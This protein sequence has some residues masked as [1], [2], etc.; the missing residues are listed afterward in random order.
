M[1]LRPYQ[2]DACRAVQNEWAGGRRRT[3]LVL[4][5]GT[6][7]TVVFSQIAAEQVERGRR[8]L[9]LAHR[10]ELLGQA[11]DKLYAV[12]GIESALEKGNSTGYGSML[13]VT[14]GSVQTMC[15][16]AR[17]SKFPHDYFDAI[18]I[19][20]AHHALSVSYQNVLN[21]FPDADVLG[22][23]A[24]PDRGDHRN[25][26][27]YF[28]SKAFEYSIVDAIK[29]GYLCP[30]RAQMIP[31]SLDLTQVRQSAGDYDAAGLGAALGPYLEQIADCFVRYAKGRKTVVF[32]PLIATSQR[33][34]DL[35]NAR[36]FRAAQVDGESRDRAEVLRDFE[37]GRYDVLCNSMLLTEGWDCPPVDCV[38]VL[39]PT[40]VRGLYQQMV[41]RGTRPAPGKDHLL[42][43]DFL[44]MSERHELCRPSVLIARQADIAKR[45]DAA[46]MDGTVD[47]IEASEDAERDVLQEREAALARQLAQQRRKKAKL[48]DPLQYAFSIASEDLSAYVPTF[49][50]EAAE[51][52]P[53][54]RTLL[55]GFGLAPSPELTKG[56]ASKLLDSIFERK[57]SGLASPKQIR[58][59]ERYGFRGVGQ[60][61]AADASKLIGIISGNG[62]R[63]P[64]GI[65]PA[66]YEVG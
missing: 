57:E 5:T 40:K 32:L 58:L 17:L 9:I 6:G 16:A 39:R 36:G 47:L 24:T 12:T 25:L 21:W 48:V 20:E 42:L 33:F 23:T 27:G 29:D 63:V 56:F 52:T 13:P 45:I 64:H 43:L 65:T 4:P 19:D 7:K 38:V 22:V 28:A 18:I 59:L 1:K 62:W 60:W 61:Q 66:A 41:G 50:W 26:G 2:I 31:L 54:Q 44:W 3:L 8:V 14:V 53:K 11:A 10:D 35:L 34:R 30:I 51:A 49:A 37:R 55:E 46:T 15:R